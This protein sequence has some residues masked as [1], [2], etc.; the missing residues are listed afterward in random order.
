MCNIIDI[1]K[2][3]TSVALVEI[4]NDKVIV[5]LEEMKAGVEQIKAIVDDSIKN[6]LDV[7]VVEDKI[8]SLKALQ[9]DTTDYR[10]SF[11][12]P[13][14][15]VKKETMA[16]EK[17][18]KEQRDRL[19]TRKDAILESTYL[20]A[21]ETIRRELTK[22]QVANNNIVLNMEIFESFI[23]NQ[24]K[25][26]GMLPNEKGILGKASL[27]KISKEFELHVAPI[28]EAKRL[29]ELKATEQKQFEMYLENLNVSSNDMNELEAVTIN[30]TKMKETIADF[31]PHIIEQC[32]RT[33]ENKL[34]LAKGNIN[35]LKALEAQ[36]KAEAKT[37]EVQDEDGEIITELYNYE[38]N[39]LLLSGDLDMVRDAYT[40]VRSLYPNIKYAETKERAEKL[41]KKLKSMLDEL[42]AP[43]SSEED[44]RV[45][46]ET[47]T[48]EGTVEDMKALVKFMKERG[49]RYE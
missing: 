34:G 32:E 21:E 48:V 37:V 17:V 49:M 15:E 18:I 46:K 41:G 13:M 45:V 25:V 29:E 23:S 3:M 44:K 16:I 12:A 14:D 19:I 47:F 27:E 36:R 35:T 43:A 38:N 5:N 6:D 1:S 24:R 22:L 10:K 11:T 7:E 39:L 28:R 31:Y 4:K 30:L 42:E 8:K 33:I 20:I 40:R 9:E 2:S 26:K